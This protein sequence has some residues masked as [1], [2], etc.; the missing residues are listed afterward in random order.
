MSY[1]KKTATQNRAMV[2]WA[3][4]LLDYSDVDTVPS[5]RAEVIAQMIIE[6]PGVSQARIISKIAKAI[7]QLRH[8]RTGQV[9]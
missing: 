2:Q 8:D 5:Q 1:T 7:R 3:R 4:E 9:E 6:F